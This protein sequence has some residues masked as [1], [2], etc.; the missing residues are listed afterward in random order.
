M[1]REE[2]LAKGWRRHS[3]I[4]KSKNKFDRLLKLFPENLNVMASKE[5]A[6]ILLSTY[7]CAVVSPCFETEPWIQ[8]LVAIPVDY[9]K[10]LSCGRNPRRLHFKIHKNE[11]ELSYETNASGIYQLDRKILCDLQPDLIYK[12]NNENQFHLKNWLA[13]RYK[14][15][16]WPDSFNSSLKPAERKLKKFWKKYN[17]YVSSAYIKLDTYDEIENKKYE[18][19]VIIALEDKKKRVLVNYLRNENKGLEGANIEKVLSQL[20]N[21][22]INAFG[23]TVIFTK[24]KTRAHKKA[25]VVLEESNITI[26]LLKIFYR[27]SPYSLSNLSSD[28][29]LP[30]DILSGRSD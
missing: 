9:K 16:T 21:E 12:V 11:K 24:D 30:I 1:V 28:D 4:S 27:F 15:N 5:D 13:E 20:E 26:S 18:I 8:I 2:L 29:P 6:I 3:V 10:E 23:N 25:V 14:Q 19:S 22:V 17:D 7:D